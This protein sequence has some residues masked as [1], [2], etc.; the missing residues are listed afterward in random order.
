MAKSL[1]AL[2]L[3]CAA[4]VATA[5]AWPSEQ[6]ETAPPS[7]DAPAPAAAVAAPAP[8]ADAV[9]RTERAT[10]KDESVDRSRELE[11]PDGTFVPALNGA[12]GASGIANYWGPMPWSKIV[13][14]ERS[15][16]G[17]DWYRHEDGSYSTTQMVWRKDL[18]RYAAMT[19]VAHPGPAPAPV[20][21]PMAKR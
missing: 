7:G 11:L 1:I 9:A 13:G 20:A 3:A 8:A 14:V 5:I 18:G 12:V 4:A 19:R 10:K 6:P 21:A 15:S 2:T 17:L 16:A